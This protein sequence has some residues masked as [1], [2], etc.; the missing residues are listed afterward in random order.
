MGTIISRRD[1]LTVNN[2]VHQGVFLFNFKVVLPPN[3]ISFNLGLLLGEKMFDAKI[4]NQA[5]KIETALELLVNDNDGNIFFENTDVLF[6]PEYGL[7]VIKLLLQVGRN[8]KVYMIW[9]GAM[10]ETRLTYSKPNRFDLKE[11]NIK[12]YVDTYVVLR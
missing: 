4:G 2:Q 3:T 5:I 6:S 10:T 8:R 1:F 11:Y 9:P 12:Y 7:D